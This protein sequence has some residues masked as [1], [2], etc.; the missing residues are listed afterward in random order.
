MAISREEFI[1]GVCGD[2]ALLTPGDNY[3]AEM[4]EKYLRGLSKSDFDNYVKSLLPTKESGLKQQQAIPIYIPMMD[5]NPAILSNN[6]EVAEK[7]GIQLYHRLRMYNPNTGKVHLSPVK[8]LVGDVAIKRAIQ[9]QS[10]KESI[11]KDDRTV[12]ELT[13]QVTNE[14]KG[15]SISFPELQA[16][17]AQGLDEAIQETMTIRGG[18]PILKREWEHQMMETGEADMKPLLATGIKPKSTLTITRLFQG[19]QLDTNIAEG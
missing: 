13:G 17:A 8:H 3:N 5:P 12:N 10:K 16:L 19:M 2:L 14:S 1:K 11:P 18:N 9:L 6:L 4:L 7:L 15:S